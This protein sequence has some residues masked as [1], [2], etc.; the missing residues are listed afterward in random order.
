MS[1]KTI[2]DCD[3]A[4]KRALVRCDFNVPLKEGNITD[5]TRIRAA[6]PTIEYLKSQGAR[7]ILMS[8]LGRPKGEKNLKYSLMPVAKRLSELLGQDVKMLP[9]CIGDEVATTVSCMKNGDIVLLENLRFY[10]EEEENCDAFVRKLSQNGDIFVNDAFGTAHRAHA[11]TAGLAAYLPAVGGFLMEKEDEFLGKI[12]RNPESPFVA[13]IGGSKVSSKIAVLESLLPKSNVMV[14]GGGMAYTFL[15]VEGYSIGQ[16]LL[17]N[18]YIDV[19]SSFLKKAKELDVKVILPLDHV[20]ASEFREDSIPE[21]VDSVDIPNDKVGMDIGEKTLRKIEEVLV[22]AK[23]VI[24]NGPLGV[25]E[26][27]SFSKG[28]AKVA[29]YVASCSG[30]TVVGGGDSVAAVNKFNLSE[31]ITHVSTGGGASLEYLEGKV[32]PGIKVLEK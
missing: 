9:D 23:T 32:L 15:K 2:K 5:D 31:K 13:I 20:V 27:N 22:S 21:Y 19:A 6:L 29:E 10:K 3:F 1:I 7:V 26:F 28:T 17:E 4:G 24:W 16:S 12:L 30:I 25:F 18:E 11:S 14:I 8:H